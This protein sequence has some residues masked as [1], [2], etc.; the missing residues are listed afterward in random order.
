[1]ARREQPR[2]ARRHHADLAARARSR[3]QPGRERPA[4]S[5]VEP[6]SN[7]VFETYDAI[8]DAACAAWMKLIATPET[9]TSIAM[10]EWAHV[11]QPL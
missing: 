8:V 4:L 9:I 3:T 6:L 10:R 5:L 7:R 2:R 1:M 11:G